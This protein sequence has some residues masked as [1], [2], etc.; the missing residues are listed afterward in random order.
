[1]TPSPEIPTHPD[2]VPAVVDDALL[3]AVILAGQPPV[4]SAATTSNT[5]TVHD[6]L[7]VH[8]LG[9]DSWDFGPMI[10]ARGASVA[11][12]TFDLPGF[13]AQILSGEARPVDLHDLIDAVVERAAACATRPVAV[14]SSLGGHVALMAAMAHPEAFAGLF[15]MAPGG[16]VEA[17][18]PTA[19][20]LRRYYS[21]ESIKARAHSEVL[22][23]SR[24]IFVRPHPLSDILAARKLCWYRASDAMRHRFAVPFSSIVDDVLAQPILK[25]VHQLQ[26]S[27][28]PMEAVFGEGD[29]VVP[30]SSGRA[31]ERAC[32]ATLTIRRGVGH[33]PHLEESEA[34][35]RHL[36]VFLSRLPPP[37]R[38]P[39][40]SA[41]AAQSAASVP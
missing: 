25:T 41:S 37:V 24:R 30:L 13:G 16:L 2:L 29:M 14:A 5:D 10:A 12:H 18:R 9:H 40:R 22:Q 6:V 26:A 19:A 39:A 21:V 27:R 23:N 3:R 8:G 17:P 32:G 15:L 11:A 34:I 4:F 31:L 28:L 36:D 7:Y 38:Q 20:L 33:C 1:M 35:A